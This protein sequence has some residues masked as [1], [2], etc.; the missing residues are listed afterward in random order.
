M[1][2]AAVTSDSDLSGERRRDRVIPAARLLGTLLP[3]ARLTNWARW[4]GG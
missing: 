4:I 3:E 1:D 2:M